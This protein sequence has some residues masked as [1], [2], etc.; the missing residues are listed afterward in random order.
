L[1]ASQDAYSRIVTAA[2]FGF[3]A[4][5]SG[6]EIKNAVIN[7]F[8]AANLKPLVPVCLR[9]CNLLRHSALA[10]D[11]SDEGVG[12]GR[13]PAECLAFDCL[14]FKCLSRQ[15]SDRKAFL[16]RRKSYDDSGPHV[17]YIA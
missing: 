9:L 17:Q 6:D 10:S 3:G 14:V 7:G 2:L 5:S 12:Y 8:P 16:E 15:N 13:V 1:A 4:S 11:K